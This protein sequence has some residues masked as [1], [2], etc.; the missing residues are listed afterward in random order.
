[1]SDVCWIPKLQVLVKVA[2]AINPSV[3]IGPMSAP[4]VLVPV[5]AMA[6]VPSAA[7]P[8]QLLFGRLTLFQQP[9]PSAHPQSALH[10]VV[11]SAAC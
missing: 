1:M 9:D 3:E 10:A 2:R 6:Q 4:S 7:P 5:V 8:L 11:I